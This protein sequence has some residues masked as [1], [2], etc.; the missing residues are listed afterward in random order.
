MPKALVVDDS[1]AVRMVLANALQKFG[2][3]VLQAASGREGLAA[4]ENEKG[5]LSLFLVD[6]NMPEMNGLEFVKRIRCNSRFEAV[7]LMMVTTETETVQIERAFEAGANEYVTKP[8][9]SEI[10]AGKLRAIGAIP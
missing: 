10:I 6:W 8:F 1:R 2:F 5:E 3:D 9:T 4:A 7:P